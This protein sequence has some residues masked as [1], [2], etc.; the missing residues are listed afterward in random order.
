MMV[1]SATEKPRSRIPLQLPASLT[2][3]A[4]RLAR[5]DG[6]SLNQ[7]I[8]SAVARKTGTVETAEDFLRERAEGATAGDLT[9]CLDMAPDIPPDPQDEL[10][11]R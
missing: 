6:V 8:V 2:D 1:D 9:R 5:Q 3:T 11:R 4:I 10:H 7:W